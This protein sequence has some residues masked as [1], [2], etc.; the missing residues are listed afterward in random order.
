MN[1]N[2][3]IKV[4]YRYASSLYEA[5]QLLKEAKQKP[6]LACDFEVATKYLP[7]EIENLKLTLKTDIPYLEKRK[8]EAILNAT[9][10]GH[11]SHCKLTHCSIGWSESDSIVLILDK[12]E[13]QNLVLNFL[14]TTDIPQVWHNASYDFKHIYYHT[15]KFPKVYEDSQLLAKTILNH[16][17]TYKANT[18]LK[19]LAGK[20]YGDWGLSSDN[21]NLSQ[22]Y[23]EKVIKYAAID[24]AATFKLWTS[25]N[26]YLATNTFP[27]EETQP[28]ANRSSDDDII[29]W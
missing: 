5:N 16:V 26:D 21:F 19:D 20:W 14:T 27:P 18:G 12:P 13:V 25:L 24:S 23:D 8:I 29:A 3:F 22:M 11:P 2:Q 9:A 6:L 4:N 15:K 28:Q 7:E 17:E 1:L 10:L